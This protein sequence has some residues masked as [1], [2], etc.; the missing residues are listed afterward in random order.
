MVEINKNIFNK[1]IKPSLLNLKLLLK[2][3]F[4]SNHKIYSNELH[5][6]GGIDWLINAQ[7]ITQDGGVSS[8]YSLIFGWRPSYPETSGY[9]IPTLFDYYHLTNEK[10]YLEICKEIADWECS[11]QLKEGAFQGD[12]IDKERKAIVFNTG[13]VIL[14]LIRA[15]KE[16]KNNNYLDCAHKA[17]EFLVKNQEIDGNWIKNSFNNVAH[18]YNVRTAW[19]LLELFLITKEMKFKEAATKNLN[20]ALDQ[21]NENHWFFKNSF[22]RNEIPLLHCISYTIRGFLEAGIILKSEKFK[23]VALKSSLKLLNYY[24]KNNFLPARF[25]SK[26]QSHD[27]YSCLTGDAQLSLIWLKLYQIYNN[28]RFLINAIR[29]NNYLKLKQVVDHKFKEINGAIKGSDP[30]W[31]RYNPFS[32][33]NWATKFFCD[34]LMIEKKILSKMN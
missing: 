6:K 9:I 13:Q 15:F 19:A 1:V 16:L 24:E 2:D 5:L 14:G 30:I 25:N 34:T 7:K 20:W 31:G 17:G 29:L 18:T 33:P 4:K 21:K 32:F 10:H 27:F 28:K 26:W 11:I 22:K 23:D 12:N 8:S 3:L